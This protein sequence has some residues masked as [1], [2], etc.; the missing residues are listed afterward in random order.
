MQLG[1]E[2]SRQ[3][4]KQQASQ[5][6][7]LLVVSSQRPGVAA[8]HVAGGVAAAAIKCYPPVILSFQDVC[9]PPMLCLLRPPDNRRVGGRALHALSHPP[10]SQATRPPVRSPQSNRLPREP[11]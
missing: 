10:T 1:K 3:A 6:Q 2:S 8:D 11:I 9:L 7:Q 5:Q 4:R